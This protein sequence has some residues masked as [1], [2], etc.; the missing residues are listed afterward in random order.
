MT[1]VAKGRPR[2]SVASLFSWGPSGK[3]LTWWYSKRKLIKVQWEMQCPNFNYRCNQYSVV[4]TEGLEKWQINISS[5][6]YI[7]MPSLWKEHLKPG[8]P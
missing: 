4:M 2:P 7:K 6:K 1:P 3:D 8:D 5:P